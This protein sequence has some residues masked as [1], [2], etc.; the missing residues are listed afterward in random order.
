V[1]D[2][3]AGGGPVAPWLMAKSAWIEPPILTSDFWEERV[4]Q[5]GAKGVR[6]SFVHPLCHT[7]FD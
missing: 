4:L 2:L 5:S 3:V 1:R 6:L 7:K